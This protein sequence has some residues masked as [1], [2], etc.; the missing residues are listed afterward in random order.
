MRA[1]PS[2]DSGLQVVTVTDS[3]FDCTIRNQIPAND[4]QISMDLI[5]FLS[6]V[7]DS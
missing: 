5:G 4:L 3:E 6:G 1:E 7:A 2:Y